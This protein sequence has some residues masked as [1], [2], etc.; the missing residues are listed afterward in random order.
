MVETRTGSITLGGTPTDLVGP[1]LRAGDAAPEFS[2][3]NNALE[4]VSRQSFAGKTLIV[5]T[6][7]SLDT[8]VCH[9]ETNRFNEHA[10]TLANVEVLVVSTDLPFGQKRWCASEH[11]E[12]VTTLSAHRSREFGESYGVLISG[13]PFDQLLARA[14]FV[15]TPGGELVHVEYVKEIGEHPN[16]EAALDAATA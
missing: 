12:N 15:V 1:E 9:E 8:A 6:V 14:V 5:A 4:V 13:G 11:A 7:P 16:Y 10:R 2:L 3:Q